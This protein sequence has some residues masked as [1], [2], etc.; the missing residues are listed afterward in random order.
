MGLA[1]KG[2]KQKLFLVPQIIGGLLVTQ[3]NVKLMFIFTAVRSY[4]SFP[5]GKFIFKVKCKK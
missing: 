3:S 2:L 5:V 1:P 4:N